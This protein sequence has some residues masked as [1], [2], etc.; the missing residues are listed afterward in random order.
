MTDKDDELPKPLAGIAHIA[1]AIHKMNDH[2]VI[3]GGVD[4][5]FNIMSIAAPRAGSMR[6]T[7][8]DTQEVVVVEPGDRMWSTGTMFATEQFDGEN[9]ISMETGEIVK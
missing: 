8:P 5:S 2:S 9:W 3:Q 4:T 7:R 6:Y 1:M